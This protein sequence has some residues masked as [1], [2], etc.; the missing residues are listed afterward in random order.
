MLNADSKL[1]GTFQ[2]TLQGG[3]RTITSLDLRRTEGGIWDTIGTNG[4]W[5]LGASSTLGGALINTSNDAVNFPVVDGAN[6]YLYAADYFAAD[7]PTGLF[8]AGNHFTLTVGFA[9]GTTATV[10]VTLP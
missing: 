6:F 4:Y 2:V 1:D 7:Y 8:L 3:S 10:N 5:S 9:D